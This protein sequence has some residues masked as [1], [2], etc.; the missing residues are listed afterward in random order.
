MALAS[1]EVVASI[2]GK[3][4][5]HFPE[6]VQEWVAQ[7]KASIDDT[8]VENAE[9]AVQKCSNLKKSELAQL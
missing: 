6:R 8:L 1:A 9:R 5:S 2:K 3:K 4:T 7:T